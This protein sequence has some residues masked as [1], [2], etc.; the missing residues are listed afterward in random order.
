MKIIFDDGGYLEFQRSKKPYHVYVMVAA[1]DTANPLK[2]LVNSAEIQLT[3]LIEAVKSIS[4][5]LMLEG[6]TNDQI[7]DQNNQATDSPDNDSGNPEP[8]VDE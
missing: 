5:P 6:K 4:G 8:Q 3:Q 2:L 1:R 7:T